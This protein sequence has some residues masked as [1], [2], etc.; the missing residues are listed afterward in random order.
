MQQDQILIVVFAVIAAVVLFQLYNVL[1]KK[2]GRQPEEDARSKPAAAAAPGADPAS[3]GRP[4][5]LD[6]VTLA[7]IAGLKARDPNFD[8]IRFLDGARQAHETIVRAYAAG[9]R[10]TLKP[11]LTPTVMESFEAGI[12]AREARGETEVAEFLHP[13]RA[14]LELASAE[15]NR[16]T[17]KVRFLAELRNRV[18][19]ADA[20]AE[21]QVEERRVAELWTFERTLGASDPNWV[22]ARTEPA[23]A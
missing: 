19:S 17:A 11:L 3:T 20:S 21:E 4:N 7:S 10:E 1:G 6:A 9:D 16:A 2:V 18:K 5:V 8:P 22:L 14:D 23:A 15:E 12:A 13:A